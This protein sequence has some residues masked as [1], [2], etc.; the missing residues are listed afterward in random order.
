MNELINLPEWVGTSDGV[1]I[2]SYDD[3]LVEVFPQWDME[4]GTNLYNF[5]V[6]RGLARDKM[7]FTV[8][9]ILP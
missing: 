4:P 8:Q 3:G 1:V 2:V 9:V 6:R 5:G 7:A